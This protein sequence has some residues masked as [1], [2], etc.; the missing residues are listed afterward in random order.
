VAGIR[1][2]REKCG[3]I[4]DEIWMMLESCWDV[5]PNRRSSMDT[6]YRFFALR[7]PTMAGQRA[8]L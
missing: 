1:P 4:N 7:A 2:K 6:L 5:D 8:R 3:L